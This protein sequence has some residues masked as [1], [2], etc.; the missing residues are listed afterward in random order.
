MFCTSSGVGTLA[1]DATA[2]SIAGLARLVWVRP[3]V[4]CVTAMLVMLSDRPAAIAA[5]CWEEAG[6]G[7]WGGVDNDG[8]TVRDDETS[9]KI[10][11]FHML[12]RTVGSLIGLGELDWV[13]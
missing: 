4:V 2:G 7:N 3:G 1:V 10:G 11:A 9:S 5:A 6:N 13:L 12:K 8:W